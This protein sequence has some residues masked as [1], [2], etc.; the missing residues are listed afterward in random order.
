[1]EINTS[2]FRKIHNADLEE[3]SAEH[4]ITIIKNKK[5]K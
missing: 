2:I 4:K 5:K 1:M 3:E